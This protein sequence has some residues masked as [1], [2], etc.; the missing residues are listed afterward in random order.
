MRN[1]VSGV[2][3]TVRRQCHGEFRVPRVEATRFGRLTPFLPYPWSSIA[4]ANDYKDQSNWRYAY[5]TFRRK[6]FPKRQITPDLPIVGYAYALI[7][8][9]ALVPYWLLST[10]RQHPVGLASVLG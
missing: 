6:D 8:F 9:V 3:W 7:W 5:A 1:V 4:F 10:G 2:I